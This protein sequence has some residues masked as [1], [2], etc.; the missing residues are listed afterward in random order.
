MIPTSG[1][2]HYA[3]V[4]PE[5]RLD[6][7]SVKWQLE[8]QSGA[9]ES[10]ADL[11]FMCHSRLFGLQPIL[12]ILGGRIIIESA[13]RHRA[14]A[15]CGKLEL[16]EGLNDSL[17]SGDVFTI[18]RTGT[19]DI[20]ISVLRSGE[21]IIAVGAVTAV[22]LGDK[23]AVRSEDDGAEW[24]S[25]DTWVEIAISGQ[26][27]QL[28]KNQEISVHEYRFSAVRCG[29]WDFDPGQFECL[30][31]SLEGACSHEV[32]ENSARLLARTNDALIQTRWSS[33][34]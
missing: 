4:V 7:E 3:G 1:T 31:I 20:G 28:R 34:E 8:D 32:I 2:F 23:V 19:G 30:A 16:D 27:Y 11:D 14:G 24:A 15:C 21:L 22:T 10:D 29:N 26:T 25:K 9:P 5:T 12:R 17:Q 18:A 6:R 33:D 13:S